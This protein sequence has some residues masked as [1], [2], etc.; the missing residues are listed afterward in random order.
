MHPTTRLLGATQ[1]VQPVLP[2]NS[3]KSQ[4]LVIPFHMIVGPSGDTQNRPA[5]NTF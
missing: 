5:V 1:G 2:Q 3:V 4:S